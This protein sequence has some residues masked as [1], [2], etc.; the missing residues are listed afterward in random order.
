M[1]VKGVFGKNAGSNFGIR[2]TGPGAIGILSEV[3]ALDFGGERR[4][5]FGHNYLLICLLSARR[6]D[7][8]AA[9]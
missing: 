8:V 7:V 5:R 6:I 1:N 3:P 9:H 4:F 2:A